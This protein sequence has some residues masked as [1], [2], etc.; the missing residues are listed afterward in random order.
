[1]TTALE[2]VGAFLLAATLLTAA[3]CLAALRLGRLISRDDGQRAVEEDAWDEPL[4]EP[5]RSEHRRRCPARSA[6]CRSFGDARRARGEYFWRPV[7]PAVSSRS[8]YRPTHE[9]LQRQEQPWR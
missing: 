4:R 2:M 1:M 7:M 3:M 8:R 6:H 5:H 9:R